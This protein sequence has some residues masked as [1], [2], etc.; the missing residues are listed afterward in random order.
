M[1]EVND[2]NDDSQYRTIEQIMQAREKAAKEAAD[3]VDREAAKEQQYSEDELKNQMKGDIINATHKKHQFINEIKSGLGET[4]REKPR[5][6]TFLKD[7][8]TIWDKLK[9]FFTKF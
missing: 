4:I 8:R 3:A 7:K 5:E 9:I 2:R 1:A 6:V